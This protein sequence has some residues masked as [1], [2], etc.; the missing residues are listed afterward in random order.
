MNNSKFQVILFSFL[1]TIMA[2]TILCGCSITHAKPISA[3]L[4][5]FDCTL[6]LANKIEKD[7][8]RTVFF[9]TPFRLLGELGQYERALA[10]A[11]TENGTDLT[12]TARC[13]MFS[14]LIRDNKPDEAFLAIEYFN[15]PFQKVKMRAMLA[16]AFAGNGDNE[17]ADQ[18]L[19]EAE[20]HISEVRT[21]LRAKAQT[22]FSRYAAEA[23]HLELARTTFVA[24]FQYAKENDP[25]VAQECIP[26]M[27][28]AGLYRD[29]IMC[30]QAWSIANF[31]SSSIASIIEVYIK[32][33][34][35]DKAGKLIEAMENPA[36]KIKPMIQLVIALHSE[37][38]VNESA[39]LLEQAQTLLSTAKQDYLRIEALTALGKGYVATGNSQKANIQFTQALKLLKKEQHDMSLAVKLGTLT[40]SYDK[41]GPFDMAVNLLQSVSEEWRG[42]GAMSLCSNMAAAGHVEKAIAAAESLSNKEQYKSMALAEI[43]KHAALQGNKQKAE[44]AFFI[45]LRALYKQP[46]LGYQTKSIPFVALHFAQ[47]KLELT[48]EMR[49][50]LG[51]ILAKHG[52]QE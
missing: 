22:E 3:D 27:A 4:D 24:T 39:K 15:D 46:D 43:G 23:G 48:D 33:G 5:I 40:E 42:M 44:E 25:T 1:F 26:L 6:K 10:A 31:R 37:G 36:M 30:A 7:Y 9:T 28:E 2:R 41:T 34:L 17:Q 45:A 35:L 38:K 11:K 52:L 12:P 16:A 50:E 13:V 20:K 49:L 29:A 19:T 51:R 14:S 21:D 8:N 47:S 18:L 32:K